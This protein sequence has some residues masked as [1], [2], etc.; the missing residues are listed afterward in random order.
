MG[1]IVSMY[2][3]LVAE[4]DINKSGCAS[5]YLPEE[6]SV[7]KLRLQIHTKLVYSEKIENAM[8]FNETCS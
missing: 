1:N 4:F 8:K 6:I 2:N 7:F 3:I 5:L